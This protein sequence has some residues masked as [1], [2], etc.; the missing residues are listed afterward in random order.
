MFINLH[1]SVVYTIIVLSSN[2]IRKSIILFCRLF[3]CVD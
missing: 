1:S 2:I 3:S